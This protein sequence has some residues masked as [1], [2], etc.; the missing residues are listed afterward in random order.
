MTTMNQGTL[1]LAVSVPA[2]GTGL[3]QDP[4]RAS[5]APASANQ[6]KETNASNSPTPDS[7]ARTADNAVSGEKTD[8][9]T[10]P[11]PDSV[12]KAPA[13]PAGS[14]ARVAPL[15]EARYKVQFTANQSWLDKLRQAQALLS[16]RVPDGDVAEVL[17]RGLTLLCERLMKER[18]AT[19]FLSVPEEATV[20]SNEP[21]AQPRGRQWL[22]AFLQGESNPIVDFFGQVGWK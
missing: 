22:R 5:S 19:S 13:A 8:T 4:I 14:R 2:G 18:F 9:S 6:A 17:E 20:Q 16:H 11:T 12:G 1:G 15:G 7:Y 10:N 3:G 21:L